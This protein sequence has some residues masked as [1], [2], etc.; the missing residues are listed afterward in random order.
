MSEILYGKVRPMSTDNKNI[1]SLI[2]AGTDIAGAAVGGA[3]GFIADGVGTA[4]GASVVGVGVTRVLGDVARRFL[5][6][7]ETTRVGATAAIAITSIKE[8]LEKG[9]KL[10]DDGFFTTKGKKQSSADE[11][12]EGVLLVAKNTHEEKK[13]QYLG[14][15][16]ENVS[17]DATCLP[18]EANY[19]IHV[20]ESLTYAQFILLHLFS[21][22]GNPQCLR[23]TDY[24]AGAQIHYATISLLHSVHELCD[25]NLVIMQKSQEPHHTIVMGINI[26][27]PA[28][29]KLAVGGHRLHTL[30]GLSAISKQDLDELSQW[31]R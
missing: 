21:E 27:C 19:L 11:I 13:T 6:G 24:G 25:L 1:E 2:S 16:F 28:D 30:L 31:L 3:L 22:N 12:F 18:N 20:A 8:R 7:R 26:I 10:R 9:E 17:F 15:L 4:A 29:L 5:S 14:H 23:T